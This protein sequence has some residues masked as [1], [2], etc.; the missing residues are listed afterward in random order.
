MKLKWQWLKIV[1]FGLLTLLV[2]Q[3]SLIG[4]P[5]AKTFLPL[6]PPDTS[7]TQGTISSFVENINQFYQI[8]MPAYHQYSVFLAKNIL[9]LTFGLKDLYHVRVISYKKILVCSWALAPYTI[10]QKLY[11]FQSRGVGSEVGTLYATS[12]GRASTINN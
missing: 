2:L 3:T 9:L 6:A 11:L 5:V 1:F 10:S 7:S 4:N 12:V 8:L